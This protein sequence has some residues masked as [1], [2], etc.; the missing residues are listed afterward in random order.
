MDVY[1]AMQNTLETELDLCARVDLFAEHYGGEF[2]VEKGKYKC[3]VGSFRIWEG[4]GGIA[5]YVNGISTSEQADLPEIDPKTMDFPVPVYTSSSLDSGNTLSI[6]K[7]SK[8][9]KTY[10]I[11]C[12]ERRK[13]SDLHEETFF[14]AIYE[15]KVVEG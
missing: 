4:T 3:R 12:N 2:V 11:I 6:S 1:Q 10:R 8:L 13:H 14:C 5:I 7:N 9:I 15:R